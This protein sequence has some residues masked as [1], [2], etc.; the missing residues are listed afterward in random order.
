VLTGKLH[1]IG[2]EEVADYLRSGP[3]HEAFHDIARLVDA[4]L[5]FE[6]DNPPGQAQPSRPADAIALPIQYRDQT[7]GAMHYQGNGDCP[8]LARAAGAMKAV[9]E[10]ML[11]RETAVADLAE[12]LMTNYEE[13]NMLYK[14]LPS[15]ATKADPAE[16]GEVL[17]EETARTLG[18]R[19]VSLLVLDDKRRNFTVLASRGL[20]HEIRNMPIPISSSV[21]GRA[22]FDEE[23]LVV[24]DVSSRPDLSDM[25]RGKYDSASFAVVRVPLRARGEA[26]GCL[27]ATERIGSPEFTARDRKL[28]EGLSAIGASALLG[29]HLHA[30]V[31]KQMMSTI[32]ALAS[33][34]DAKDHYTHDHAGRVAELCVATARELGVTDVVICRETE[35]AGLL[36]DIGK[37]GIPDAILAKS[38]KLTPQEFAV[39]RTH[40]QIGADIVKHVPGLEN[41]AQAILHHHERYDGLGYPS[42]LSGDAAPLAAKLIAIAD[43]FDSL[44][45]DRPYRKKVGDAEALREIN[46]CKGTQF[47]PEVVEAFSAVIKWRSDIEEPE[48][49]EPVGAAWHEESVVPE[50]PQRQLS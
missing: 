14:L 44:T 49:K 50:A 24:N 1:L 2:P 19:R 39:V 48:T 22:M 46:N 32:Q 21:A 15:V 17:V 41:V 45:S 30:A 7:L 9:V 47:D 28:L 25:S 27:T 42:G 36:H 5:T 11:G 40:V 8:S 23:L 16:I 20:P 3:I 38:G 4:K 34:V 37:I 29:C 10:H 13:L 33:A 35:L 26:L 18:C 12:A 31:G 6:A 43:A